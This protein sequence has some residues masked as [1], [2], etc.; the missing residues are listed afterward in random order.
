M[1]ARPGDII[2][3]DEDGAGVVPWERAE[4][5]LKK[6]QEIDDSERGMFPLIRRHKLLQKAIEAFNRI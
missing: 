5:V 4:E 2:V 6:A 3:A 1:T